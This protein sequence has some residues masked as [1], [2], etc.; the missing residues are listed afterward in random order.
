MSNIQTALREVGYKPTQPKARP[1]LGKA[2]RRIFK[3]LTRDKRNIQVQR[4][5]AFYTARYEGCSD[6]VFG[7]CSESAIDR[8][9]S[10]VV[11][12]G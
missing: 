8:L 10:G 2:L 11:V 4:A 6:F 5:G 9:R 7:D 12:K 3:P 1:T